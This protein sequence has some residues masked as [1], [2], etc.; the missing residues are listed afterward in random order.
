MIFL[1]RRFDLRMISLD[2]PDYTYIEIAAKGVQHAIAIDYD[3]VDGFVYWTDDEKRLIQRAQL[4]GTRKTIIPSIPLFENLFFAC[5]IDIG[6]TTTTTF[7]YH[8]V[9]IR[10]SIIQ[11][12]LQVQDFCKITATREQKFIA[13]TPL[14]VV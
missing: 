12:Q 11:T 8:T 7:L 1:A 5:Y 2:T 9:N 13:A 3:P 14:G 10:H 4:D 6:K